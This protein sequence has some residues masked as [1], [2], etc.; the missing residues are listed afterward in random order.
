MGLIKTNRASKGLI[1]IER[2]FDLLGI[3][4]PSGLIRFCRIGPGIVPANQSLYKLEA[5]RLGIVSTHRS[6]TNEHGLNLS[7]SIWIGVEP[8]KP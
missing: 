5:I 6:D 2:D 8:N 3:E 7:Q 4:T 1:W